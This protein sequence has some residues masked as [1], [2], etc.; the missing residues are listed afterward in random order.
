M[1][2]EQPTSPKADA[3]ADGDRASLSATGAAS[4]FEADAQSAMPRARGAAGG[5]YS[6]I[7]GA[8]K[9]EYQRS[10]LRHGHFRNVWIAAFVSNVGSWMEL[11]GVQLLMA[12]ITGEL[13]MAAY[14]GAAQM[15]PILLMGL[16]GGLVADR[17]DRRKLLI[18]TQVMLM[19]VAACVALASALLPHEGRTL[20]WVLIGLGAINAVIMSFN[21][22]AWQVLTPRLVPREELTKAITL[23]GIQFNLARVVGPA[24]GGVLMHAAGPTPLFAINTLTF[25]GVVLAVSRTPAAPPPPQD[26]RKARAQLWSAWQFVTRNRGP[27]AVFLAMVV[28]SMFAAPLVRLLSQFTLDAFGA[29]KAS[30]ESIVGWLLA[31]QGVG[32]VTGGIALRWLP[33]WY[34]KHHFIPMA[35]SG[36]GVAITAFALNPLL[37]LGWPIMF[38]V[39]VFWIWSFNQ[40]WAAMQNLVPDAMRGRVMAIANTASFGATALG[41]LLGGFVGEI[42][43][44]R[45]VSDLGKADAAWY[46]AQAAVLVLSVPLMVAGVFML[47]KRTPEVDG[48]PRRPAAR[49][50][51]VDAI[52][53]KEHWP[54]K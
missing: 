51:L 23:N 4:S 22:P 26:G 20:P 30:V 8:V 6:E 49:T 29:S 33:A 3:Q 13:K 1:S 40:T 35:L 2:S 25:L 53:A 5:R 14:L 11:V 34:P 36:L 7:V 15:L 18:V 52:L 54:G 28:A 19:G 45:L 10:V 39:G 43:L 32:A 21:M 41:V 24:L 27:L 44:A 31:V 17:V 9:A 47:I 46:G 42:V 16:F 50:G 37:W 48:M 12:K 38:V